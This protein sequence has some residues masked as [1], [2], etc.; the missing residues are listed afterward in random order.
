MQFYVPTSRTRW[1]SREASLQRRVPST[2]DV[3]PGNG[4]EHVEELRHLPSDSWGRSWKLRS[5]SPWIG[6]RVA[7]KAQNMLPIQKQP[8]LALAFR[9]QNVPEHHSP[10]KQ[11]SKQVK[12]NGLQKLSCQGAI[13]ELLPF[14]TSHAWNSKQGQALQEAANLLPPFPK[15]RDC[16]LPGN[17]EM[18][19]I[20]WQPQVAYWPVCDN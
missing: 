2:K 7:D 20:S 5:G 11:T 6:E 16:R 10:N 18:W 12:L 14:T 8:R 3:D 13:R 9:R 17:G 4:C 19:T 15:S 1:S